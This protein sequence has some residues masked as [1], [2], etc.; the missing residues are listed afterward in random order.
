MGTDRHRLLRVDNGLFHVQVT[1]HI[2]KVPEAVVGGD[3]Y[4]VSKEY[5]VEF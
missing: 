4:P 3:I 1:Y 5:S 2:A